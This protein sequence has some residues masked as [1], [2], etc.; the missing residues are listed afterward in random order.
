MWLYNGKKIRTLE[1][2]P[3]ESFGFI[4]ILEHT[5]T[6]RKY[7]GKKFLKSTR[8]VKLGKKE[9][10]IIR[11]ERKAKGQR[12]RV[13]T[14]KQVIKESD[15]KTYY[16]SNKEFKQLG[17]SEPESFTR[18][19]LHLCDNK[20]QLTY[21]EL[22]YQILHNAIE[23]RNYLNDHIGNIYFSNLHLSVDG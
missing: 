9:L 18:E 7:I 4:Y 10:A 6:G 12:G 14:K 15:W 8:N 22:K 2:F 16:G 17:K 11:A 5:P 23:D 1:D 20:T 13:P 3:K 21:F 19:I